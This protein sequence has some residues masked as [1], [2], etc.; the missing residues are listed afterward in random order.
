MGVAARRKTRV[1]LGALI[2]SLLLAAGC[3]N[4][5]NNR[6]GGTP[7]VSPTPE[8][9]PPPDEP[10]LAE[11]GAF[12]EPLYLT[13]PPGDSRLFVVEKTGKVRVVAGGQIEPAPFLDISSRVSKG[14]EQGLLSI[15]F[16]PDYG[17]SGLVYVNYTDQR[18]D[19]RI[20]EYRVSADPNRLDP[21]SAREILFVDQPFA[22]HNGGLLSFDRSGM[23]IAGMGDGGSGGDPGNRA[24]NLGN[25]LGK[26]LRIDPRRPPPGRA[27]GI[28]SDNPFANRAG[29]RPEV[30]AYGLRNPWRFSFDPATGDLYLADVGQNRW[31]E[32]NYVPAE[33]IPGANFGWRVYEGNERFTRESLDQSQTVRPVAVYPLSGSTC[34]VTGGYVY[35]GEV[36]TLKGTY[37]YGDFCAGFVKGFRISNGAAADERDFPV[38][39]TGQLSSFGEDASGQLYVTSLAGKVFRIV[40]K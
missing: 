9:P 7:A 30:W 11:V 34:S 15:A 21:G 5:R 38:L 12:D 39:A 27:Y 25:L 22:N 14:Y 13:A 36:N 4:R 33:S 37:L 19:T 31:E 1:L 3:T 32:V 6:P 10:A 20:V 28:P 26:L 18:G 23:L 2:F 40:R 17:Q 8:P 29:A 24:Q 35:R 16:A